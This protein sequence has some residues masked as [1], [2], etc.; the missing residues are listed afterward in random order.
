MKQLGSDTPI[1]VDRND[2]QLPDYKA[3]GAIGLPA[4]LFRHGDEEFVR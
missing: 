2:V 1:G 4:E 3:A